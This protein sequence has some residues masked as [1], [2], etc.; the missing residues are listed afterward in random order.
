MATRTIS[1]AGGNWN[2]V[3]AW[4]EGAEPT[5]SD[6]VVATATSGNVT[7]T[8][9][10][11]CKSAVFTGYVGTLTHPAGVTWTIAGNLTLV[12]GMTYS[13]EDAT[14]IITFSAAATLTS[15]GKTLG[16]VTATSTTFTTSGNTACTNFTRTGTAAKTDT[17]TLGGNVTA[18]GTYTSNGNSA[19]NRVLTQSSVKGTARTITAAVV[20]VSNTDFQDIVGAGAG[21][22]DLSAVAGGIGDCGGN[23]GI[24]GSTPTTWYYHAAE[25]GADSTSTVGKW[26]DATNGGGSVAT[27]PPLPQDTQRLDANSFDGAGITVT[28]DMPRIGSV[29]WT[30]A[31]NSPTWTTS[32]AA[33]VFG[34]ITLISGM[35]LTASTQT[36][37][38][39]G[40]GANTLK[41]AGKTWAKLLAPYMVSGSLTLQDALTSTRAL[42]IGSGTF[43]DGGQTATCLNLTG[44]APSTLVLSGTTIISGADGGEYTY[45]F[46]VYAGTTVT[47]T[48]TIQFTDTSAIAKTLVGAGKTFGSVWYSPGAGTGGLTVTGTNTFTG[49]VTL[50]GSGAYTVTLPNA[51]TTVGSMTRSATTNVITITRTGGSGTATIADSNNGLNILPYMSISNVTVTPYLTWYAPMST[52]GGGN[53]GWVFGYPMAGPVQGIRPVRPVG[54]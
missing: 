11:T 23:T 39:E 35:T 17:L 34:S 24:T 10:A 40:R 5:A 28:Q 16:T 18:S 21:S 3:D 31:T 25:A 30:G 27:Y 7:L 53:T 6:D 26:F 2:S 43:N 36:Y 13:P 12:S 44:L 49:T 8:A 20:S 47:H 50:D 19:V 22:W 29:D 15:A 41:S 37:T 32:T 33:S 46:S 45:A 54:G 9:S 51:T 52:D 38:F 48:G 42:G 4:V 14:A 1:D